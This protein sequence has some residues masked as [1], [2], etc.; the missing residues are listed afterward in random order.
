MLPTRRNHLR[1]DR[2]KERLRR[3]ERNLRP[4]GGGGLNG[5]LLGAL[6]RRQDGA[7]HGKNGAKHH[8]APMLPSASARVY[9]GHAFSSGVN[10]PSRS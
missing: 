8:A 6:R 2:A 9:R 10:S 1:R 3:R 5:P 7:K 4:A